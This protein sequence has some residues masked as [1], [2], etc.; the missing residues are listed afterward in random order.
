MEPKEII[1]KCKKEGVAMV[2]LKF[3]DMP[4][5]WQHFTLPVSQLDAS[6][7]DKGTGFDGSSIRGF[8]PIEESDMILKPDPETF[9]MDP[10]SS[11]KVASLV[12]DVYDPVA[13]KRFEE[14]PRH[15]AQKAEKYL[16]DSGIADKAYFGPEA[17]FFIFNKARFSQE[18][19]SAFHELTS[20]EANWNMSDEEGIPSDGYK[21]RAK[22]GYFPVPPLDQH[23]DI[24][25]EMVAEMEKLGI[26]VEKEHH[27]VATGGQ[28]EI[29]IKYETLVKQADKLMAFKYV[30]KNVALRHGK[31]AT[32]MPKPLLGDN[33][34]GM[35]THI[36]LW[37]GGTPLF[38]DAKGYA[39]LS[40]SALWFIGGMLKHGSALVALTSPTVN[41]YKRLVPGYEAPVNLVYSARNRSAAIRIPM[42]DNSPA[43]KRIEFRPPDPAC[44]PYLA[45]AA[46]LLAGIDGIKKQIDPG[47]PAEGNIFKDGNGLPT[48]PDS[49]KGALDALEADHEFLL[50]DGV[51]SRTWVDSWINYKTTAEYDYIRMR[52]TPSEF[53]LYYDI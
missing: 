27:E 53:I 10:F 29:D 2:D 51:F 21:I 34:S 26:I 35:H 11:M 18:Q 23:S 14:D 25:K 13:G 28:A 38:F 16:Q 45:F 24:R 49:L 17:E 44:N 12:C 19:N 20:C 39:G 48:V 46:M 40:Q 30:V 7:F 5:S 33:G 3:C 52:P 43:S 37:K 9:F 41:S 4:G 32:F 22:E 1:E 8:K 42:Y 6:L 31:T 47:K 15:I 50:D 36:S